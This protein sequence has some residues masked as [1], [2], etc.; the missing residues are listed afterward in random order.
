MS[1]LGLAGIVSLET[2]MLADICLRIICAN[3]PDEGIDLN[4]FTYQGIMVYCIVTGIWIGA[5]LQHWEWYGQLACGM[6]AAYL[7]IASVQ[8]LQTY[9]VYDFLHVVIAP[10]GLL[11]LLLNPSEDRLLSLGIF[12]IIQIGLFMRM[13]GAADGLVFM[14][15]ALFE[16]RF[17]IGMLTYLLHM[18]V[19]FLLLGV[20]QILKRN[21]NRHGNLKEPV[22]F[23]PY[24]AATVW[25]FL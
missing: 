17:G 8:D 12:V 5:V 22:A 25:L 20:V 21:V 4:L 18:A 14:V 3:D 23:V 16:S 11:F 15:C 7:L 2:G 10:V 1:W 13:Y 6:L 9:Q 19:A 24:I